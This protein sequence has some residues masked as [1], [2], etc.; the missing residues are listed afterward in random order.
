MGSP[1]H[2]A[3]NLVKVQLH[4]VSA[5]KRECETCS[6]AS[7]G[8]DCPERPGVG[9]ALVGRLAWPGS[10]FGPLPDDTILLPDPR[11]VLEPDFDPFAARQMAGVGIQDCREVFLNA[12]MTDVSCPGWRGRALT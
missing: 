2:G 12:S 5:D 9:I 1:G 10:P 6:L 7:R 3:R 8:T 11:F 4:A